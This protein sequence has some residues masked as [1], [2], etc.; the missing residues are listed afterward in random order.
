MVSIIS[1]LVVKFL[2][3]T[4]T[5]FCHLVLGSQVIMPRCVVHN[6]KYCK[7]DIA[8]KEMSKEFQL[9]YHTSQIIFNWLFFSFSLR[10]RS[11]SHESQVT[12]LKGSWMLITVLSTNSASNFF[13]AWRNK[14]TYV[15]TGW[16]IKKVEPKCVYLDRAI[17]VSDKISLH[18]CSE[19]WSCGTSEYVWHDQWPV[20][21]HPSLQW[22]TLIVSETVHACSTF[23]HT[24]LGNE[25]M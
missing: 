13:P 25:H 6:T 9:S 20:S 5:N 18:H 14:Y 24:T 15:S 12:V 2:C 16:C 22:S 17:G 21:D 19:G 23:L 10:M 1:C 11:I 7:E 3:R 4:V 8:I